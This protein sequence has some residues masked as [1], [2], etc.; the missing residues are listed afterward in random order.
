MEQF[1]LADVG[2]PE[3]TPDNGCKLVL[4]TRSV[5]IVRSMG[6]KEVQVTCLSMDQ[7]W[8][9]FLSKVGQDMWPDPIIESIMKLVV[10][11][12]HGLPLAIVTVA[13]CMRGKSDLLAWENA[14]NELRG[15]IRNIQYVKDKVFGCLKF[16]YDR[17]EQIDRDC[18]LYCALYPEDHEI[19]M[20]E[21]I[22][23]WLEEG[24]IDEMGT[25]KAM[26]DSG[27]FILQKLEE[28]CLLEKTWRDTHIKMHD[29][30]RDMTLHITKR[31]PRFLVKAGTQLKEVP[32]EQQWT[33]DL[34]RVS[35]MRNSIAKIPANIQPLKCQRLTTFLLS[36]NSLKEIA[37]SFFIH[38]PNLKI[39]DLSR[40]P[41]VKL[42]DSLS[43]LEHLTALLLSSCGRLKNVPS[44]SKLKALRKLDLEKTEISEIPQGLEILVNLRYL[45]LGFTQVKEIPNE[46]LSKLCCLQYLAIHPMPTRAEVGSL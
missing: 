33:E 42:P 12:C 30:V 36:D 44:L 16:S 26:Q 31:S 15:H 40:N 2:I 45:N 43:D 21:V 41:I 1:F 19:K 13:S 35:L 23:Y 32:D 25:R 27:L 4:T 11:E 5:E 46:L 10:E 20:E 22:E 34:E 6:F 18:F 17:L 7:A 39:L 28:N 38:M 24:L 14:L 29:V 8:Q 37:E 3:P 9:L